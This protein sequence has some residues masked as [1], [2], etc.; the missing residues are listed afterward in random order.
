MFS[1]S[2]PPSGHGINEYKPVIQAVK[3]ISTENHQIDIEIK[4]NIINN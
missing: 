3:K 4:M 2:Y 1:I